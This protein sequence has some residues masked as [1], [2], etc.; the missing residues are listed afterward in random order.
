MYLHYWD[1]TTT[2]LLNNGWILAERVFKVGGFSWYLKY[3]DEIGHI[4]M[5]YSLIRTNYPY[6]KTYWCVHQRPRQLVGL[7]SQFSDPHRTQRAPQQSTLLSPRYAISQT[8]PWL[9]QRHRW[10]WDFQDL[11]CPNKVWNVIP[12]LLNSYHPFDEY[13]NMQTFVSCVVNPIMPTFLPSSNVTT[14]DFLYFPWIEGS[15]ESSMFEDISGKVAAS[16][17]GTSPET[18]SSNSWFPNA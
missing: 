13:F 5:S 17:K 7:L 10:R 6:T 18:L 8:L 15:L 2:W 12:K 14:C 16:K 1:T 3:K 9:T 4:F 11:K